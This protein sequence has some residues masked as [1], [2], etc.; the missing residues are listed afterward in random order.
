M[1]CCC[2]PRCT[3]RGKLALRISFW[4]LWS[5]LAG[6]ADGSTRALWTHSDSLRVVARE[7]RDQGHQQEDVGQDGEANRS[8]RQEKGS[9]SVPAGTF[10]RPVLLRRTANQVA[11]AH[12]AD[13]RRSNHR[14]HEEAG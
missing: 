10:Q 9:N 2:L 3:P 1:P 8:R 7:M 13:S 6:G 4:L 12:R 5:T 11:R 14:A